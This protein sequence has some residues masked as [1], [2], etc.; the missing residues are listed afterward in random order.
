M[1]SGDFT[2]K[3]KGVEYVAY[4]DRSTAYDVKKIVDDG[5]EDGMEIEVPFE[6]TDAVF[7]HLSEM[8]YYVG[9]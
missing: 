6:E 8:G 4:V 2:F 1:A 3:V 9:N 5:S 7:S